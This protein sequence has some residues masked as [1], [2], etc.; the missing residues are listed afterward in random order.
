[1]LQI[2]NGMTNEVETQLQKVMTNAQ[3]STMALSLWKRFRKTVNRLTFHR[4]NKTRIH[5]RFF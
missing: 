3:Y 1:M 2:V 4:N 5:S